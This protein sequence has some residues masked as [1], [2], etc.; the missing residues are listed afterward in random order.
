MLPEWVVLPDESPGQSRAGV[1]E[2]SIGRPFL[3]L[4]LVQVLERGVLPVS[5]GQ[6]EDLP[7][8][9]PRLRRESVRF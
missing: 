2:R 1:G 3:Q 5:L 8:V 4:V 6:E 7:L 9:W